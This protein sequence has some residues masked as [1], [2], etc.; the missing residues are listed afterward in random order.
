MLGGTQ[1]NLE[2]AWLLVSA[3]V[4]GI[5]IVGGPAIADGIPGVT[6]GTETGAET[7]TSPTETSPAQPVANPTAETV[8]TYTQAMLIGYAAT[9]QG[10]YQTA[11]INFR[12]AL[13]ER[14][15]DRYALAAIANM[16]AYIEEERQEAAR[17]EQLTELRT[18]LDASVT[19]RDW[20][21]ANASINEMI[22]LV[23]ETSPERSR[24]VTYEAELSSLLD[25]GYDREQWATVCPGER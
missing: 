25:G 10:D 18:Q 8:D 4:V 15:G 22:A 3:A 5:G 14:P 12:R 11:L 24:L 23:P 2:K 19:A 13:A 17:L 9:E 7:E 1:L 20:A 16:E 6:L 21:C